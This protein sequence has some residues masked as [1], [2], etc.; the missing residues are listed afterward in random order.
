VV[1]YAVLHRQLG[2]HR[3]PRV[4]RRARVSVMRSTLR[5]TTLVG[6]L[7][8]LA[9]CSSA[10]RSKEQRANS[11]AAPTMLVVDNRR[12]I[13]VTMFLDRGGQRVRLGMV[14]GPGTARFL[15]PRDLVL[16]AGTLRVIAKPRAEFET[17]ED[18]AVIRPG[19]TA[20]F[21]IDMNDVRL[22]VD[23]RL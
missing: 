7:G 23:P 4:R 14:G 18:S 8:T 2:A 16:G 11:S 13:D 5:R 19:D 6:V 3:D 15:I 10:A 22:V 1:S 12:P 9:A 17:L 20:R 21:T